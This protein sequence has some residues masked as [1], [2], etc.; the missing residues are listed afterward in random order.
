ML[1]GY[2]VSDFEVFS[3]APVITGITTALTFHMR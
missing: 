2:R 3:V 1:L